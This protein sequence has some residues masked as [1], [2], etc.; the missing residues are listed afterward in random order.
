MGIMTY[1][2][3]GALAGAAGRTALNAATYLD[4]AGRGRPASSTPEDTVEV[5]AGKVG[6]DVPGGEDT[7]PNRL[8]GLGALL[9]TATG[10]GIGALFAALRYAGLRMPGPVAVVAAGA[11]AMAASDGSMA[12]LGVTDPREWDAAS[13]LSDALPHLAYGA[14]TVATLHALD[15]D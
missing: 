6:V 1:I 10:V 3:R 15:R 12:V 7:R 8:T 4:M 11:A 9:G 13:W 2:G 5:L 14:V